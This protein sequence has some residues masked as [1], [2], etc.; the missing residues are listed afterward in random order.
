MHLCQ[1]CG[2]RIG[3]RE[4]LGGIRDL[5][6]R[7][8]PGEIMPSGEC[9]RCGALCHELAGPPFSP[10]R[11][12]PESVLRKACARAWREGYAAAKRGIDYGTED[13]AQGCATR[14]LECLEDGQ[15]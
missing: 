1:G 2:E 10:L 4:L 11:V 12:V 7:V 8:A 9:P 3:D 5:G 15:W 13:H 6:E 14:I